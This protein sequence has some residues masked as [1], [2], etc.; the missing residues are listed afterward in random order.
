MRAIGYS[1]IVIIHKEFALSEPKRAT[2][3]M[4]APANQEIFASDA[5][6]NVGIV[7]LCRGFLTMSGGKR[8]GLPRDAN[9]SVAL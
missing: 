3:L 7:V 4:S 6:E 1:F 8:S 9:E 5:K 2:D